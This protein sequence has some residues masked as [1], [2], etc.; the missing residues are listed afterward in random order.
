MCTL[1]GLTASVK[2]PGLDENKR[3]E[4]VFHMKIVKISTKFVRLLAAI[5]ATQY[6]HH[7]TQRSPNSLN[8]PPQTSLNAARF[9]TPFFL[10]CSQDSSYV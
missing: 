10:Y 2:T 9:V 6:L 5:H 3:S 4:Q 7:N 8:P 1:L